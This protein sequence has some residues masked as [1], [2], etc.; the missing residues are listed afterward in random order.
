MPTREKGQVHPDGPE[1]V[2]LP[3]KDLVAPRAIPW[4]EISGKTLAVDGYN[5]LYQFLATIRQADGQLFTDRSGSV[6]SHLIGTLYRTTS[7]LSEGVLPI[8]VFD[9]KPPALKSATLS[10]RF[11]AKERAET[12]WKEALAAGDLETAKRKASAT[13]RLTKPMVEEV[14]E[15]LEGLGVPTISAPSEGESQAAFL[16]AEGRVWGVGSEDYD[17]LL[18]GAPRLIRGLAARGGRGGAPAAQI[19]DRTE[20]LQTLGISGDELILIGLLIGTDFNDGAAGIGPKRALKLAQRHLGF[21]ASLRE[22]GLDPGELAPV[23]ELFRHPEVVDVPVPPFGPIQTDALHRLLV[24]RHE[25]GVVRVDAALAR[26]RR[27]PPP[28]RAPPPAPGRQTSLELF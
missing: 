22:A 4:S 3:L 25:F 9:G 2:G 19:I 28:V 5:A 27:R 12:E 14:R 11:R 26:A 1:N 18:F 21:D 23:A 20:T 24:E 13:S 8:W 16:A 10:A 17:S 7:L 15:L 6:T